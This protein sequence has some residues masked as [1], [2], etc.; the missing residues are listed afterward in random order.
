LPL[1]AYFRINAENSFEIIEKEDVEINLIN[2]TIT[3]LNKGNVPYCNKSVL[4]KIGNDSVNVDVCL[5]VDEEQEYILTAPEGEY[6]VEI[7][8]EGES[9]MTA[10]VLLTGKAINVKEA[11]NIAIKLIRLP[12]L[13]GFSY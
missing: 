1:Q 5:E 10:N 9:M 3:I 7:V 4:I 2:R 8:T 6:Q 11:S 12:F 13:F